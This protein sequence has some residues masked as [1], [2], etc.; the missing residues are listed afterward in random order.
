MDYLTV[1]EVK[2]VLEA[3]RKHS[4]RD[5][6]LFLVAYSH[7]LRATEAANLTTKDIDLPNNQVTVARKKGS[8]KTS[9]PLLVAKGKSLLNEKYALT[10]WMKLRGDEPGVL[11]PSRK[12]G[13]A[14]DRFQVNHLFSVY[15]EEAGLPKQKR[16]PHLLKHSLAMHMLDAGEKIPDVRQALGH[17]SMNSTLRYLHSDDARAG[18]ALQ[19]VRNIIA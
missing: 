5:W 1:S 14:I 6:V 4:T 2:R 9:Q 11:F 15:A 10:Q 12:T 17:K 18:R 7:G 19:R 13:K 16:H 8:L 3:A